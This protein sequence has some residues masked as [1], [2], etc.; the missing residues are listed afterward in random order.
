MFLLSCVNLLITR[1]NFKTMLNFTWTLYS[2]KTETAKKLPLTLLCSRK[3]LTSTEICSP[4]DWD[5]THG[6][7]LVTYDKTKTHLPNSHS[8]THKWLAELFVHIDHSDW[9]TALNWSWPN[10]SKAFLLLSSPWTLTHPWA[11]EG[12]QSFLNDPSQ[13]SADLRGRLFPDQLSNHAIHSSQSPTP[14]SF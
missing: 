12:E 10:F 14:N 3:Q 11:M 7:S 6:W 13:E 8:F 5:K 4:C 9:S 1:G 2:W